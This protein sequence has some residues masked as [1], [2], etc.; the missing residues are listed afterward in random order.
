MDEVREYLKATRW[1]VDDVVQKYLRWIEEN[2][3]DK[4]QLYALH[5][6]WL[7][8]DDS[9]LR[10]MFVECGKGIYDFEQF[11]RVLMKVNEEIQ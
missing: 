2:R 6:D 3:I 1:D 9:S 5:Q 4:N 7:F 11:R 8:V 10:K